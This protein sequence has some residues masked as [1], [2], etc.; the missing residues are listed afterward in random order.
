MLQLFAR[1]IILVR[2]PAGDSSESHP[3]QMKIR[4]PRRR[5]TLIRERWT[6]PRATS[7]SLLKV[8]GASVLVGLHCL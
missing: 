4:I 1:A 7:A 2:V 5:G 8:A 3:F 6:I